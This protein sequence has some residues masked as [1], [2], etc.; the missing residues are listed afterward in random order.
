[1]PDDM[2]LPEPSKNHSAQA[3][4]QMGDRFLVHAHEEFDK[5]HRLQ[6]GN[7]AYGAVVQYLKVIAGSRGWPHKSNRD[8][9]EVAGQIAA[10]SDNGELGTEL[11]TVYFLG[12][13]NYYENSRTQREVREAVAAAD[14]ALPKLKKIAESP[15]GEFTI[16]SENALQRV[17]SLTRNQSHEMGDTSK[18]GFS[19]RHELPDDEG[20]DSTP[21]N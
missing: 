6:A 9:R 11:G 16:R 12:H 15:P 10:E 13:E 18:V 14:S 17:R 7:K 1:M 2:S 21:S 20:P 5:G 3:R 19:L 8:F 4:F